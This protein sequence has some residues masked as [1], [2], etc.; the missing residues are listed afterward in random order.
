MF[1]LNIISTQAGT[2]SEAAMAR[3]D[4]EEAERLNSKN[5]VEEY[6]YEIRGKVCDELEDFMK[7][8]DKNRFSGE[9]EEAENWL[10]ED[11]EYADKKTYM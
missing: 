5:S 2:A 10:Y 11:G 3:A 8:E 6:I 1:S 7:P 9:L 4:R